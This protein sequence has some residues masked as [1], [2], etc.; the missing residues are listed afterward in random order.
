[1]SSSRGATTTQVVVTAIAVAVIVMMT[2]DSR[3]AA[4]SRRDLTEVREVRTGQLVDEVRD[5]VVGA[6]SSSGDALQVALTRAGFGLVYDDG[7]MELESGEWV[8]DNFANPEV[9]LL[10]GGALNPDEVDPALGDIIVAVHIGRSVL[11]DPTYNGNFMGPMDWSEAVIIK[12]MR[13]TRDDAAAADNLRDSQSQ[14]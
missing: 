13:K 7:D 9:L 14:R 4:L 6:T 8:A 5:A 1:M 3:A 11:V 12:A 2:L 10:R